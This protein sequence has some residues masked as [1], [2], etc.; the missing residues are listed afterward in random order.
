MGVGW[1]GVGVCVGRMRSVF[2]CIDIHY[3]CQATLAI[4]SQ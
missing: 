1:G 2:S 4:M 3:T